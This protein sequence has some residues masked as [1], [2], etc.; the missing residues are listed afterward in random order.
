M[1]ATGEHV[2]LSTKVPVG[3][4]N[5]FN[6]LADYLFENGLSEVSLPQHFA[7]YNR[8]LLREY[9]DGLATY[10]NARSLNDTITLH[11]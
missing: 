4:H 1:T 10:G 2:Q 6:L 7:R 11:Q 5:R 8:N 3:L 9:H